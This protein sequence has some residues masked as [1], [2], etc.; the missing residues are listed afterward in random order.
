MP[1]Y[2]RNRQVSNPSEENEGFFCRFTFGQFFALLVLEVFT[3][4]FVF[5]LGARY[6]PEFLGFEKKG[7]LVVG[8]STPREGNAKEGSAKVTTT[9]DPEVA[10]MAK[11]LMEKA[12]TPELKERLAE[13]LKRPAEGKAVSPADVARVAEMPPAAAN[14]PMDV[15]ANKPN[16]NPQQNVDIPQTEEPPMAKAED[17]PPAKT[18]EPAGVPEDAPA[19]AQ[20]GQMPMRQ[21]SPPSE[22]EKGAVRIKSAENAKYSLQVGSYPK[23]TEANVAVE[24]WKTKGYSAY[25]MI[26]DIPDRG[27]WYRVR[28]GG[29][30]SRDEAQKY[31]K[32]FESQEGIEALVVMNEQ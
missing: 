6:G 18:G 8:D 25:L 16:T 1:E 28:L 27:R 17:L 21:A 15:T 3:L 13:M 31:K 26:A 2:I 19:N 12:R 11:D 24:K 7:P 5:Y 10:A 23:M 32:E 22:V 30:A 4:F 14:P 9:S 29:F 20:K